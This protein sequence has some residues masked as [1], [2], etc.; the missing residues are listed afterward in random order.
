[1]K[2]HLP[3]LF[4]KNAL[5][6]KELD[7]E[8]FKVLLEKIALIMFEDNPDLKTDFD[9]AEAFYKYIGVDNPNFYRKN[10]HL[11]VQPFHCI[12]KEGFRILPRD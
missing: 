5:N 1:M 12:E 2:K 6:Y 7:F 8:A 9:K 10:M 11:Q 3:L 4:K